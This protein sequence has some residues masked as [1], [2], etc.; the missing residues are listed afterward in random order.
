MTAPESM[1]AVVVETPGTAGLAIREV[2]VQQPGHDEVLVRVIATSIGRTVLRKVIGLPQSALP[3]IPGHEAVAEIVG[4]GPAVRDLEVGQRVLLYYYVTCGVCRMCLTGRE[5]LCTAHGGPAVRLGEER[6]GALAEYACVGRRNVIPL[7]DGV[8]PVAA[9]VIPDAVATPVHIMERSGVRALEQMIIIGAAGGVGIHLMQ[10]A[11]SRGVRPIAV[12]LGSRLEGLE[13]Y[14]AV[15][16]VDASRPDWAE[17]IRGRG[18]VVVDFVGSPECLSAGLEALSPSGRLIVLNIDKGTAMPGEPWQLVV[19][20]TAILGSKYAS[21]AQFSEAAELLRAGIV[22][23]VVNRTGGLDE[24]PDMLR[25][26]ERNEI[27]GR[28][29]MVIG[30]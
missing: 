14:G 27:V 6:D 9:T 1:R 10:I 15:D 2:P 25:A 16:M 22:T 18:D 17:R 29:A 3:R 7:P 23:P 8:D 13:A 5:P 12:D 30:A 24:A 11:A 26:I 4:M 28:A 21:M 19:G 20:E